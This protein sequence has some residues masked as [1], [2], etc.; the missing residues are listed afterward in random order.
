MGDSPYGLILR[1]CCA[2]ADTDE[3]AED[4]AAM[5]LQAEQVLND[6]GDQPKPSTMGDGPMFWPGATGPTPPM[7]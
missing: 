1:S 4:I 2:G 3:I 6:P 5:R 7:L